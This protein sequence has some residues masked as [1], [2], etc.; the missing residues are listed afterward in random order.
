MTSW[1]IY[2]LLSKKQTSKGPLASQSKP[3]LK[4]Q[5]RKQ[6][7]VYEKIR[8]RCPFA[9][10]LFEFQATP[11]GLVGLGRGVLQ[12]MEF[13]INFLWRKLFICRILKEEHPYRT[14]T[15]QVLCNMVESMPDRLQEVIQRG[16]KHC[17]LLVYM[18]PFYFLLKKRNKNFFSKF[19]LCFFS[20]RSVIILNEIS[21]WT[22][23]GDDV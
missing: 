11:L 1:V 12:A 4:H 23:F 17:P 18:C 15:S 3:P 8:C 10:H 21:L 13:K 19:K 6:P 14:G 16:W 5:I 22:I 2:F 20:D 7:T 9:Y